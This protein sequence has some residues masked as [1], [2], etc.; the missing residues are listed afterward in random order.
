MEERKSGRKKHR[1]EGEAEERKS[2][3]AARWQK[4][5]WQEIEKWR[6]EWEK[7]GG[8]KRGIIFLFTVKIRKTAYS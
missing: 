4:K 8:R 3:R 6:V 2:G 1:K 7:G 5:E